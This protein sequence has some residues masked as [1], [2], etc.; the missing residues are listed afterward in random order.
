MMRIRYLLLIPVLL[1]FIFN[2]S[3]T[4]NRFDRNFRSSYKSS[5][6]VV[7]LSRTMSFEQV[8]DIFYNLSKKYQ[9][10]ILISEVPKNFPINVDIDK[11][12]W[13]DALELILKTNNLWYEEYN[14]YYKIVPVKDEQKGKKT[15]A[16]GEISFASRE[17]IISAI[18]FEADGSKLTQLGFSWD[19]FRGKDVNVDVQLRAADEKPTLFQIEAFPD[20]DF[21]SLLAIFKALESDQIGE[22]VA[23]PQITVRSGV[24]GKIQVGSDIAVTT[25]DFAGN[26]IN[27]FFSTGSIIEVTPLVIQYDTTNFI[28]LDLKIERS[29]TGSDPNRVEIK[30]SEAKTSILLLN[31]EE[32]VIGGLYV[33]E[34][35]ETREGIPLLKDL[36][37]WFF[38]LRYL[39][40]YNTLNVIKKELLIVIKAELVPTLEER[41]VRKSLKKNERF[42]QKAKMENQ[43]KMQYYLK[44]LKGK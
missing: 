14:D 26:T 22:V 12:H 8:F 28:H 30:K 34:E 10:K 43:L 41:L 25:K 27:Q 4:Q 13:L 17:V 33:N 44:Q 2:I 18:F 7:S 11:M 24:L 1:V 15:T 32:T 20:L 21:G 19:F 3:H 31:G 42:L 6:E 29:N 16:E 38:G 39:F 5:D 35:A 9:D 37:W 40:G 36:P 23:N